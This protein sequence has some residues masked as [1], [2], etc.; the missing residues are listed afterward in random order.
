MV[1]HAKDVYLF[2]PLQLHGKRLHCPLHAFAFNAR[3]EE[4][5]QVLCVNHQS[6]KQK[7]AL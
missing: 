1:S 5:L 6:Y 3:A 4:L 2:L 7:H